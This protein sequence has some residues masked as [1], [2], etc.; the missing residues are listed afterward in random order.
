MDDELIEAANLIIAATGISS[1]ELLARFQAMLTKDVVTDLL[2][3]TYYEENDE[4]LREN[5]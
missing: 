3:I 1:E 4:P 2:M 5:N